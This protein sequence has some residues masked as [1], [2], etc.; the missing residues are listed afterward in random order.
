MA[1]NNS[2]A[3]CGQKGRA[4]TLVAISVKCEW[5]GKEIVHRTREVYSPANCQY[6]DGDISI[7]M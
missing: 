6:D 5:S 1:K 4:I 7:C 3:F 2:S